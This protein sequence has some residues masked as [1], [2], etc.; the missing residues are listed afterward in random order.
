MPGWSKATYS[1]GKLTGGALLDLHIHDTDFVQFLFGRPKSV[2]ATGI[3]RRGGSIDYVVT[4]YNFAD[5]PVV[6]AEGT[7]L[8]T[9]DFSMS[10]TVICERATLDYDLGRGA[11]AL[12]VTEVGKK[13]RVVKCAGSDG[14]T[15]ELQYML[16]AIRTGK[17]PKIVT[18]RD[19]LSAVEICEA[20][21]RSVRTGKVVAL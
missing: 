19:G 7:W 15:G 10:Y 8:L 2:F 21:A 12:L 14:Y 17:A 5:G 1:S 13:Q 16:G 6:Y 18:A 11:D 3:V 4:Q 9:G 20:E